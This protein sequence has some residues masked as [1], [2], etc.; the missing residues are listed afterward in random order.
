MNAYRAYDAIE[1]RK[2]AVQS[3]TEEGKSGLTTEAEYIDAR[4]HV[5]VNTASPCPDDDAS[6]FLSKK[7]HEGLRS[8]AVGECITILTSAVAY[9]RRNTTG[10]TAP[11]A[12][13][14]DA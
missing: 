12:R 2:W 14:K 8:D 9:A 13:F 10:I 6:A 5:S 7:L 4:R 3:L 11:A 1:E